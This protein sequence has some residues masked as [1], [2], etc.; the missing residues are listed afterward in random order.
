MV[1]YG[2]RTVT[3]ILATRTGLVRVRLD[4]GSRAYAL[5]QLTGP[6]DAGDRVVVNTTA[7]DRG[8][9]TG[10]WHV[11]HWNLSTTPA[12]EPGPG[13]LMKLRY[14]SVQCD[15]GAAE[16]DDADVPEEL[17]A[18]PVVV[19]GLHSQLPV[20]TAAILRDRPGTRVAYVMTDG[21][22][23]PLAL[24]DVV[25]DLRARELLMG[26]VTAGHA[27]GGDLEALNVASA[28]I[29]AR[30]RLG[31]EVIVVVMG[32][33]VAGTG[34]R[35][36]YT[37]LEVAS[38]LDTVAWLGG[39]PVAALRCSEADE[40]ARHRG[41][42]HHTLTVLDAVRSVVDVAHP[43]AVMPADQR[44]RWHE[45]DPGDPVELLADAGLD[46]RTMGRGPADDRLAFTATAAAGV[47]AARW[48]VDAEGAP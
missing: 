7:V 43:P 29:S 4:D 20:I 28:L 46:V 18:T 9:G 21:G 48:L 44:H 33:G 16:E 1:A 42:S 19:G 5:T 14:T 8:L 45:V 35:L 31:A 23:L 24:S 3:E 10:G 37:G 34:S 36:G 30:H 11:V 25:A 6:V 22:A 26:T 39:R 27:F 15:A 38:I 13:H 41:I 32:P 17:D 47:L 40:R 2:E 12:W